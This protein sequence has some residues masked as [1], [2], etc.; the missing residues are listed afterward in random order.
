MRERKIHMY[1][2]N[3]IKMCLLRIFEAEDDDY[4]DKRKVAAN[5]RSLDHW[6]S[7]ASI[8]DND[9]KIELLT[10]ISWANNN[11]KEILE[12]IGWT[13]ITGDLKGGNI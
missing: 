10:N 9:L 11:C 8:C 12:K 2:L 1:Y 3:K 4:P 6:L 13:I 5:E 7:R